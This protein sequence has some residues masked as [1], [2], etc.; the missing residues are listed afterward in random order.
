MTHSGIRFVVW[1]ALAVCGL[2]CGKDPAN[3]AGA[4]ASGS[5]AA[6]PAEKTQA[7]VP[8]APSRGPEHAVFS[9]IDNRLLA[10]VQRGGGALVL[11]GRASFA[12][13]LRFAKPKVSWKLRQTVDGKRVGMADL[14]AWLDVPLTEAQAQA[15]PSVILRLHSPVARRMTLN[16]NGSEA[17][18]RGAGTLGLAAGWQTVSIA[19]LPGQAKTGENTL[20]LVFSKGP[21]AAVEWVQMGGQADSDESPPLYDATGKALVLPE[22]GGLAYYVRVPKKGLLSGDVSAG[23]EVSVSASVQGK[24][25]I[26]GIL[27]GRGSAVD[28][29][30]LAETIVRVDLQARVCKEARLTSAALLVPGDAPTVARPKKPKHIVFWIMDSLRADRVKTFYPAARPEVPHF[31]EL[32]TKGTIFLDT[33]VQGNESRASHAS[34]WASQYPVNH[35]VIRAGVN[36]SATYVTLGEAMKGAGFF[37]SGVSANGYITKHGGFGEGWDAYRNHIHDGGGVR[38]EDVM[39]YALASVEKKQATPFFL[40]M[41]TIDTHVSWRAKEPWFKR[42][43]PAPYAGKFVTEASGKDIDAMATKKILPSE[44]DRARI[45]AIY[46]SNVSYQDDLLGKLMTQLSTWGLLEDTLIVVTADHGDE[47]W[48]DGRVGHGASLRESLIHVPLAMYYP[49]LFPPGFVEEG[50]DTIDILPTLV[51][52]MGLLPPEGAQGMSLIPLAQGVGQGYPRPAIASQYEFAHAMR[53]GGWKVRVAGTGVPLLYDMKNDPMEK[54]DL[55]TKRPFERRFMADALS[56]FLVYQRDWKKVR[57]GVASNASP[58]LAS[59]LG[60]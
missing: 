24:A 54:T 45:V 59:D 6:T 38:G 60:D 49:P 40:Y 2:A 14:Y 56:T 7:A 41:G 46:D 34:I 57:W 23:C 10:H 39:K 53:L 35:Q 50:V 51:D 12:K 48:E 52:A 26:E 9:L 32:S 42:Y 27:R 28:L 25:P 11:P 4:P 31:D 21:S 3:A 15:T 44:R 19:T 13:Y 20:Q 55:A 30:A 33:Y 58:L 22:G 36:L 37:T 18:G 5:A 16:V 29:S 1:V 17:G 47:Q 8:V 43:D